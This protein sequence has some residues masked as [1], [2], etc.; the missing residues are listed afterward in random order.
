M[1]SGGSFKLRCE[2]RSI[3]PSLLSLPG[4]GGFFWGGTGA[5]GQEAGGNAGSGAGRGKGSVRRK[6]RGRRRGAVAS[7][8]SAAR[9]DRRRQPWQEATL[10]AEGALLSLLTATGAA[11][12][13]PSLAA[14]ETSGSLLARR[15]RL[16]GP[17]LRRRTRRPVL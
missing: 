13:R 16:R 5:G 2:P 12:R 3:G 9:P 14:G 4:S 11:W 8:H 17:P 15:G 7:R 10:A 6:E 1:I